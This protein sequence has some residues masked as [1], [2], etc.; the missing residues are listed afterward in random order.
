MT[1][2][3][4]ALE[5][6]VA[7]LRADNLQLVNDLEAEGAR[8]GMLT[9]DLARVTAEC[10]QRDMSMAEYDRSSLMNTVSD[11]EADLARVTAERD[12][13][14]AC[15]APKTEMEDVAPFAPSA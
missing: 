15:C 9:A 13:Q 14:T 1:D 10:K 11:I 4:D 3:I 7:R 5:Q 2:G 8:L 6:M 12:A